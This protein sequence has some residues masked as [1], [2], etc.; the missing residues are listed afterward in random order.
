MLE[1]L[2]AYAA[3]LPAE[4][5]EQEEAAAAL[6]GYALRVAGQA[7]AGSL[8]GDGELAAAR[9]LDAEDATTRQGLAWAMEHDPALALR[10]ATALGWWWVLRGRLPGAYRLLCQVAGGAEVGSRGWCTAQLW[11]G[12]AAQVS[13]DLAAALG[14]FTA[15]RDAVADRPP[16]PALTSARPAGRGYCGRWAGLPRRRAMPAARWRWPGRSGTRPG[17]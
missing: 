16:S 17:S 9:W 12:V 7:A 5:G 6:A 11:L 15:L 4:A 2:R 3:G 8:S 13:A 10:L 14:H 1:T